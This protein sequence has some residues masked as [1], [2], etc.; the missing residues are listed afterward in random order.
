MQNRPVGSHATSHTCRLSC[1]EIREH[2]KHSKSK[3][4]LLVSED[5]LMEAR[6]RLWDGKGWGWGRSMTR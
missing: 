3:A 2:K 5:M 1:D 6:T 4:M